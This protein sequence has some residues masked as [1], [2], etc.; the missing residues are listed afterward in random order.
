[1]VQHLLQ[2][3]VAFH[4]NDSVITVAVNA[5]GSGGQNGQVTIQGTTGTGTKFTARGNI[6]GGSLVG[7]LILVNP[8]NYTVD[9]TSLSAEPVS[10]GNLNGATVTLTMT[11]DN[12]VLAELT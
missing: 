10:G 3:V 11:G 12:A 8:G 6:S 7:N 5:G 1:M 9:P 4:P 2:Q